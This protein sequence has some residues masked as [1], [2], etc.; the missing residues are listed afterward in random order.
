MSYAD[1]IDSALIEAGQT[2]D[3]DLHEVKQGSQDVVAHL[4]KGGWVHVNVAGHT[5]ELAKNKMG[6]TVTVRKGKGGK[7]FGKIKQYMKMADA[8]DAAQ[9]GDQADS[10]IIRSGYF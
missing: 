2:E 3:T 9:L 7:G 6:S 8:L 4:K 5:Y 1:Q 10:H